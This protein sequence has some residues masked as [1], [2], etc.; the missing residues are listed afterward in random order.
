MEAA[1]SS[2]CRLGITP[3]KGY[4]ELV[5]VGCSARRVVELEIVESISHESRPAYVKKTT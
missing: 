4:V 1:R 2:P 3:P 5:V